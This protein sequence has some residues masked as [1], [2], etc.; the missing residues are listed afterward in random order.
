[1]ADGNIEFLGR[2]DEQVKIRGFR[3]ELGE[4]EGKLRMIPTIRDA[5]VV[6]KEDG[7]NK[8]L[9]AYVVSHD[10]MT[11]GQIK[12]LLSEQLPDY[13]VPAYIMQ[14]EQLPLNRNGKLDRKALPEPNM[15][16][17]QEFV[18]P[19]N[20][21]ERAVVKAF[22]EILGLDEIGID[23]SFFE[24]GGDSIKAIRIVSKLREYGYKANI[25]NIMKGKI[26]R[27]IS[28]E[29]KKNGVVRF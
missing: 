16:I 15:E 26:A 27:Q 17:I 6:A 5:A 12:E 21:A 8:Y 9:C 19:R 2:I 3:V 7:G 28:K 20:D 1:M 11:P 23:D 29:I 4:I 14:L 24:L 13:M 22:S 18:E 10:S 25:N